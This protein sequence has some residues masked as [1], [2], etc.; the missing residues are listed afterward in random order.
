MALIGGPVLRNDEP[1]AGWR[2]FTG[3]PPLGGRSPW[4]MTSCDVTLKSYTVTTGFFDVMCPN[5]D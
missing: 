4:S 5:F 2:F 1:D 3:S